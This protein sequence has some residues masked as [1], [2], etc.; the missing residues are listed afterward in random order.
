MIQNIKIKDQRVKNKSPISQKTPRLKLVNS[1]LR[2][3]KRKNL[4]LKNVNRLMY[5]NWIRLLQKLLKMPS[6]Q[7][8]HCWAVI[9]SKVFK[10]NKVTSLIKLVELRF[11][12]T[13]HSR[14][15]AK[16]KEAN[17]LRY[18]HDRYRFCR[19][20][21]LM[22][23]VTCCWQAHSSWIRNQMVKAQETFHKEC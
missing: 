17:V 16:P 3:L 15:I 23:M 6:W 10:L 8:R 2:I 19:L 11:H 21:S 4:S 7:P 20:R 1:Q 14:E 18:T 5:N 13:C 22:P 9:T 12:E